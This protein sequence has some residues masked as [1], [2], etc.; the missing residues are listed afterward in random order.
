MWPSHLLDQDKTKIQRRDRPHVF[1]VTFNH[2]HC[3]TLYRQLVVKKIDRVINHQKP[4]YVSTARES[5]Q[6]KFRSRGSRGWYRGAESSSN[7]S[8]D[9]ALVYL[10]GERPSIA[11]PPLRFLPL[12]PKFRRKNE[13][14]PFSSSIDGHQLPSRSLV[15][16]RLVWACRAAPG[17]GSTEPNEIKSFS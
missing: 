6:M 2:H 12:T 11:L 8:L 13:G 17:F 14:T 10:S 9:V 15:P 16:F 4:G 1:L 7:V 5:F 3:L